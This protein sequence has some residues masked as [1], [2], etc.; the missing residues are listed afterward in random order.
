MV[1]RG[2]FVVFLCMSNIAHP[3]LSCQVLGEEHGSF[4]ISRFYDLFLSCKVHVLYLFSCPYLDLDLNLKWVMPKLEVFLR[5]LPLCYIT[6]FL[7][8]TCL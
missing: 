1:L 2:C 6:L 4:I 7:F 3:C 5:R 8:L